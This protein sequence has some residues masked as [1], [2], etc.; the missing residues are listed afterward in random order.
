MSMQYSHSFSYEQPNLDN[1]LSNIYTVYILENTISKFDCS[2]DK[3]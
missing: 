3:E 1:V 2:H